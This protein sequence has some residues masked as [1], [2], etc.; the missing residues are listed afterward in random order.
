MSAYSGV[1]LSEYEDG[2]MTLQFSFFELKVPLAKVDNVKKSHLLSIL[3]AKGVDSFYLSTSKWGCVV[4]Y[5]ED[6]QY[7][8]KILKSLADN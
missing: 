2:V 5:A 8:G 7:Y 6:K 3:C 1:V 4:K